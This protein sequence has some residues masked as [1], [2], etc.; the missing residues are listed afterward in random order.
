MLSLFD[1]TV[2]SGANIIA[3]LSEITFNTADMAAD[4]NM[5]E[6]ADSLWQMGAMVADR[7]ES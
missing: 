5:P 3:A 6:F 4:A 7:K 1:P 2:G